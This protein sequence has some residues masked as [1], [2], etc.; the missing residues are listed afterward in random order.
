MADT[1]VNII[2]DISRFWFLLITLYILIR[3]IDNS[4][5]E[6]AFRKQMLNYGPGQIF[7]EL[8]VQGSAETKRKLNPPPQRYGLKWENTIGSNRLCDV[9]VEDKTVAKRH[10]VLYMAKGQAY[11]SP[12]GHAEIMINGKPAE[13]GNEVFNGDVLTLGHTSLRLNLYEEEEA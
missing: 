9:C 13:R 2:T 6:Y 7:G 11:V 1:V 8:V 5:S 12:L 3:L 4:L 10:A